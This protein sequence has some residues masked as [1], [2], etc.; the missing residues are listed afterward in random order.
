[1]EAS[2]IR[3]KMKYKFT[4]LINRKETKANSA[5]LTNEKYLGLLK[6]VRSVKE[7]QKKLPRDYWLLRHYD[8][9]KT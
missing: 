3:R 8:I 5:L 2:E 9:L 4:E 7:C 6:D 1:M